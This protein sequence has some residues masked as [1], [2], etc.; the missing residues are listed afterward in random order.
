MMYF[1]V[2][3]LLAIV[4]SLG[5]MRSSQPRPIET[6]VYLPQHYEEIQKL[7]TLS[8]RNAGM[9]VA[10][11]D[12]ADDG[13]THCTFRA[14]RALDESSSNGLNSVAIAIVRG[15]S[16]TTVVIYSSS[17]PIKVEVPLDADFVVSARIAQTDKE[18]LSRIDVT[19]K[20]K[21]ESEVKGKT[22]SE[23]VPLKAGKE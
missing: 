7:A 19:P 10:T 20:S 15:S 18:L 1:R 13:R 14:F 16:S 5:C 9:R 23:K 17:S 11:E 4:T 8:F 6:T 12:L 3:F 2:I 21:G 22:G